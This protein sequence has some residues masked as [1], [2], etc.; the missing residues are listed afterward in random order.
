MKKSMKMKNI[1]VPTDFS[2]GFQRTLDYAVEIAKCMKIELHIVHVIEPMVFFSDV[3][4]T[5]F[6]LQD[7]PNELELLANIDIEKI[8]KNLIERD[9][10]FSTTI[11]HGKA[12][13]EILDYADKNHIDMI[14]I[15]THG[16]GNIENILFGSTSEK[17]IRKA[18]CPVLSVRISE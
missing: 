16:Q 10:T 1:L 12:S 7:L 18:H 13:E 14:C 6:G 4:T 11:L 15:A 8:S 9:V 17:V 3:V 2:K 5:K